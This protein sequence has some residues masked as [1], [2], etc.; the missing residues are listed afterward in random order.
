MRVSG[1]GFHLHFR[2]TIEQALHAALVLLG[3][4][5]AG[6]IHQ[7]AARPQHGDRAVQNLVLSGRALYRCILRPFGHR[8]LFLAEHTLAR[9]RCIDHNAVKITR[10]TIGQ[11]LRC[12]VGHHAV[13]DARTLHAL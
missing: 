11:P 3:C 12:L 6:R 9:A 7:S 10:E 4:K 8:N 13:T 2:V 5:G 1:H